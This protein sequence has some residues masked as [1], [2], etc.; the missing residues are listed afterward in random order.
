RRE[1]KILLEPYVWGI[2]FNIF[3]IAMFM[4]T[5]WALGTWV[6]PA[7]LFIAYGLAVTVGAVVAT[8]G[9]TGGY[10]AIMI[11][12]LAAAGIP[13]GVVV[14]GVVLTRA[15]LIVGTILSGYVFYQLAIAKY[16]KHPTS[17]I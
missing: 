8:P 17:S 16:G 1:P 4:I 9:G 14:A 11:L 6:N 10:E 2:V 15:I 5:F 12:F 3:E 13:E 7:P